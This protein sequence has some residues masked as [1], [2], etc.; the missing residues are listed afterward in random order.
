MR[1]LIF[2]YVL[3][4]LCV[5]CVCSA[6]VVMHLR[7]S[8]HVHRCIPRACRFGAHDRDLRL[9]LHS[10]LVILLHV[11]PLPLL[12]VSNYDSL[13]YSMAG[14]V[15]Y[16]VDYREQNKGGDHG[17]NSPMVQAEVVPGGGKY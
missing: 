17:F 6:T 13:Q 11:R 4:V 1:L 14:Q 7:Y 12:T 10:G 3:C 2:I 8:R 16:E 9:L 5:L 15:N